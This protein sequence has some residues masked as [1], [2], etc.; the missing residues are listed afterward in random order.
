MEPL[1]LFLFAGFVSM[2][3]ALSAGQLNK[4]ADEDKPAFMQNRN[5]MVLVIM[6]GNL[7]ALTLIGALAYG[8][9]TLEWWI[10]LSSILLSFPALSVGIT[11]R[12]F[13]DKLNL[14][15]TLPL[16]LLSAGLLYQFWQ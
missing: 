11:Q 16:T 12:L 8:F 6:A 9:R 10:P 5:G 7:G 4:L 13:G 3:A 14:F 2:S 15:I 1:I